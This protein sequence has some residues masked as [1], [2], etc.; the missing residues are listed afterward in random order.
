MTEETQNYDVFIGI[1][2]TA[3]QEVR[4]HSPQGISETEERLR[5]KLEPHGVTLTTDIIRA[6]AFAI[7]KGRD[8]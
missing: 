1:L 3:F 5:C 4:M 6:L 8:V 7:V 2:Q